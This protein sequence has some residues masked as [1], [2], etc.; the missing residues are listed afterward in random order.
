M[1]GQTDHRLLEQFIEML[2]AERG[3]AANTVAAYRR[4]LEDFSA[5]VGARKRPAS[6]ATSDDIRGYLGAIARRG[7]S[8]RTAARHL[9]SVRPA[10]T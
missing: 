3:A 5:F 6:N 1:S 4:D 7:L 2:I 8:P 9:S 10:T